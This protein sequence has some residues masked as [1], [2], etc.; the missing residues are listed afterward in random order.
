MS[1]LV[2]Q[3]YDKSPNG[4]TADASVSLITGQRLSTYADQQH[5]AMAALSTAADVWRLPRRTM[6]WCLATGLRVVPPSEAY[7][8]KKI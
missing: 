2:P 6:L 8:P 5:C 1:V 3:G 7:N 4:F